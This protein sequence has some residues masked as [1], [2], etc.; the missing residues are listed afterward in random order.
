[1]SAEMLTSHQSSVE[2][3]EGL[4]VTDHEVHAA[5]EHCLGH[6]FPPAHHVRVAACCTCTGGTRMA[7]SRAAYPAA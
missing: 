7:S 3:S 5:E 2:S 4:S 1:M 6:Q